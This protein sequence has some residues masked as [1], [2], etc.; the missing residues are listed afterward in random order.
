MYSIYM[1]V[2]V[3]VV[4]LWWFVERFFLRLILLYLSRYVSISRVTVL[5]GIVKLEL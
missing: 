5:Y 2:I 4:I 3:A 1:L